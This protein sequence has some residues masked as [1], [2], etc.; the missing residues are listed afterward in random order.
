MNKN[1]V[2]SYT[3]HKNGYDYVLKRGYSING[4]FITKWN[5]KDGDWYALERY[6]FKENE[7]IVFK[8]I[9]NF[10]PKMF[11]FFSKTDTLNYK[12]N[13]IPF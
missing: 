8:E 13:P 2:N 10:N 7:P 6:Y 5:K 11:L 4:P 1:S 3:Y 9:E 12:R